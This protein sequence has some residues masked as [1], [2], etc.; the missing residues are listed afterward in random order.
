M[1]TSTL[2]GTLDEFGCSK[3]SKSAKKALPFTTR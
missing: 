3:S 2:S 1:F